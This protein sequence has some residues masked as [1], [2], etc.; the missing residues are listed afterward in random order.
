MG[1]EGWA[2]L[3]VCCGIAVVLLG[4]MGLTMPPPYIR[5][6]R[7]KEVDT[8]SYTGFSGSFFGR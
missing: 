2:T 3:R 8:V 1:D 7:E 5:G 6:Q 4:W